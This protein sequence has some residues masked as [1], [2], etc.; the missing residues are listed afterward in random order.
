MRGPRGPLLVSHRAALILAGMVMVMVLVIAGC[1]S[2]AP[3]EA[4]REPQAGPELSPHDMAAPHEP[5]DMAAPNDAADRHA[6]DTANDGRDDLIDIHDLDPT[7]VLDI[8]YARADNFTGVAVYPVAR[9]LLRRDVAGRIVR[10]HRTLGQRGLGLK[11]WDC[12][13]PISVQ[14]RFWELVPDPRY[15]ARPVIEKG[16]ARQ[17]S[18]HNRGAAVDVTLVDARGVELTMPTAH[19][20]FSARAHRGSGQHSLIARRNMDLLQSSME[21][22]GFIPLATEWWH[23]DAPDWRRYPLS[24]TP[25]QHE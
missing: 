23:F 19:D 20:D 14:Q 9:C 16:V 4:E 24:D 12:Y 8:R 25:L 7:I 6:G 11:L 17:G 15:V 3:A 18:R 21:A 13:R 1:A 10:V 22:E 5:H 2:A